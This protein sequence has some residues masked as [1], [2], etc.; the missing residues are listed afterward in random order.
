VGALRISE[1]GK[2][3]DLACIWTGLRLG[4]DGIRLLKEQFPAAL[5]IKAGFDSGFLRY[6][7]FLLEKLA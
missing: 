7:Y 6:R 2:A 3:V 4:R 5:Y 1:A